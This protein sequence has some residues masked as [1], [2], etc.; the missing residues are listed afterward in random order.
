DGFSEEFPE[1]AE[2]ISKI[3]LDD[4]AYAALEGLITGDEYEGDPEG[5]VQAWLKD[6]ADAYPGLI[7]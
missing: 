7:A 5:A 1:A 2:Y 4:A 6:N 3:K